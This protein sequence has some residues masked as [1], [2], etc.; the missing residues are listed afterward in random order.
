MEVSNN[1]LRPLSDNRL[2]SGGG[3]GLK[4]MSERTR[5]VGGTL[6]LHLE[7][8]FTLITRLPVYKQGEIN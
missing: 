4:G 2:H 3:M 6:E 7:P 1:G 5:L 8:Q